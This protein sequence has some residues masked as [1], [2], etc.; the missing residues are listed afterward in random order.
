MSTNPGLFLS[1]IWYEGNLLSPVF[2]SYLF[3][4]HR[5]FKGIMQSPTPLACLM[6][7][8]FDLDLQMSL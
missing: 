6:T 2:P 8:H 7:D 1:H 5:L 4:L 3:T